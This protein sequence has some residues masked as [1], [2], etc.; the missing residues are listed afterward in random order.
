MRSA[1]ASWRERKK[2]VRATQPV[3][4]NTSLTCR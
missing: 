3:G 4:M 1:V 2:T